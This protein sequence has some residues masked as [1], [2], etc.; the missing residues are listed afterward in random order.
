MGTSGTKIGT[1]PLTWALS[2]AA[3]LCLRDHPPAQTYRARLENT[4]DP[5]NALTVLAHQLARAVYDMRNRHVAFEKDPFFQRSWRGADEPGAE[6]D[7]QG[8]NLPEAL[9]TAAS[10]A[11]LHAQA[12]IGRDPLSPAL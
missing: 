10:M 12:R 4:H 2:E 11:S 6:L 5:G 9:D 8:M 7:T 3:V 1:A